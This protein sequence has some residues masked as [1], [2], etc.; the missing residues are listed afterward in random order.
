VKG[1][2]L[3]RGFALFA[4][5]A[6]LAG[7]YFD[8]LTGRYDLAMDVDVESGD[9]LLAEA[10]HDTVAEKAR[11]EK[12][13]KIAAED[14]IVYHINAGDEIAITVYGHDDLST[15]TKISP[16][17]CVGVAFLGQ[18]KLSGLT[19]GEAGAA[20]QKGLELYVKHPVVSVSVI[21]VVSETVTI[22]GACMR[23]G[24]YS[25]SDSTRIADVYAMSG[26]SAV[27]LFHGV[28]VDAADLE[29]SMLIRDG[30]IVPVD[31]RKAVVGDKLNNL[32]LR[33]DD[34]LYIA[35]RMDASVTVCGEVKTPQRR[36]YE[37]GM[38]LIETLTAVGWLSETHWSHVIIIRN[39]LVEPKMYKIDVDGI[40]AGKCRNI[41]LK[42]NDIIYVPHDN[43]GEYNVFIRK[44]LPT[45]QLINLLTSRISAISS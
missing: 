17:G 21:K 3:L 14:D 37:P 12:L 36:L 19:I 45:A 13:E 28:H 34:Y 32:K 4:A 42:P 20:I 25:I 23:P 9:A 33:K 10:G 15:T 18:I 38:G 24:Q 35:Q 6:A 40:L 29:N 26:G 31:F 43:L 27:R 41:L 1:F 2:A 44:L 5:A 39:G 16:D 7:C 8:R 22:G 30:D 11:Q